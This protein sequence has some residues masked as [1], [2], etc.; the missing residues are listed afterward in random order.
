MQRAGGPSATTRIDGTPPGVA[1]AW[2]QTSES[3]PIPLG[4]TAIRYR[5]LAVP[6]QPGESFLAVVGSFGLPAASFDAGTVGHSD[7][8]ATYATEIAAALHLSGL[9]TR[10]VRLGAYLHDVGKL[11][12]P[13]EILRKPGRLTE[14]EYATMRM[15]PIWGLELLE[16][17]ELPVDV[18]STILW[19]HEKC[20]GTGYPD[21]L[22]G[23]E[24]PL[25]ASIV[26]IADVYD[27]LTSS[28]SYRP[29]M[30]SSGALALMRARRGWWRPEVYSAF[31]RVAASTAHGAALLSADAAAAEHRS[32]AEASAEA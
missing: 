22:M 3:R 5:A 29:P 32:T 6:V 7:R 30:S 26:A 24:V 19:H 4:P 10:S 31:G 28:R 17:A 1:S 14:D 18:Q 15:H 11:M 9:Q 20:D 21:G 23:E 27:A 8:V 2:R 25:H 12:V 16:D 13:R